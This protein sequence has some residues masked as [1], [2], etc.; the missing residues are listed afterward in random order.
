MKLFLNHIKENKMNWTLIH[1][2][3]PPEDNV[4]YYVTVKQQSKR[5]SK[6]EYLTN[7]YVTKS[8]YKAGVW[9]EKEYY[10]YEDDCDGYYD[11]KQLEFNNINVNTK[12]IAWMEIPLY[13]SAYI[14]EGE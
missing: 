13:P 5:K 2:I 7:R 3:E 9:Y 14:E 6:G 1:E 8:L 11:K 4:E 10:P 12:V